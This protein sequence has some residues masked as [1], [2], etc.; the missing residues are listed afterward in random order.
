MRT[1]VLIAAL[2]APLSSLGQT[3]VPR[4][5]TKVVCAPDTLNRQGC[6]LTVTGLSGSVGAHHGDEVPINNLIATC[7]SP[8][9]GQGCK[10]LLRAGHYELCNSIVID[11][12]FLD[13]E[14]EGH[15]F[16]GGYQHSIR[17]A[18]PVGVP[19]NAGTI[20]QANTG[21]ANNATGNDIIRNSASNVPDN[22][23]NR[24]RGNR[25]AHLYI[26][27]AATTPNYDLNGK[28]PTG[29]NFSYNE[30]SDVLEDL[31]IQHT[32][33]A[34][35][36]SLDTP[37]IHQIN[38]QDN[39]AGIAIGNGS[40]RAKV[41][42]C[43]AYDNQGLALSVT[44]GDT[45]VTNCTFGNSGDPL[46]TH[47]PTVDLNGTV[48]T[49]FTGN[50]ITSGMAS[51]MRLWSTTNTVVVGNVIRESDGEFSNYTGRSG[52]AIVLAGTSTG[53][54]VVGNSINCTV[55]E[56]LGFYAI[57]ASTVASNVIVGNALSGN[58]N[59]GVQPFIRQGP[60]NANAMALNTGD[61]ATGGPTNSVTAARLPHCT[62]QSK[63][64]LYS[65]TDASSAAG[66]PVSGGG[67][68]V[69]LALCDGANWITH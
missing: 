29:V 3:S 34:M 57:D 54:S 47:A 9:G 63:G 44:G 13:L 39:W 50:T 64:N 2:L 23:E 37:D 10:L 68:G 60:N 36:I 12:S 25:V 4:T 24:H 20:L 56:P 32:F 30:D 48:G 1:L 55:S 45:M 11:R 52:A 21:C 33:Q 61:T 27:G 62:P 15:P 59:G 42:Q 67:A 69:A 31:M 22:G 53:N 46:G 35:F 28:T 51:G 41:D 16:W 18:G 8:P 38:V 17:S 40:I 58:C 5:I 7:G 6:D 66:A 43:I 14:G 49:V 19:G 65:V 26:L